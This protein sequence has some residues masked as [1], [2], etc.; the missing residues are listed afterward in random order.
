MENEAVSL[1]FS[2]GQRRLGFSNR[3]KT[4]ICSP[5]A[6]HFLNP[7]KG[8][9]KLF[10]RRAACQKCF[11]GDCCG[12]SNLQGEGSMPF[13]LRL[14]FYWLAVSLSLSAAVSARAQSSS[15]ALSTAQSSNESA[16]R[17]LT[18]EYFVFYA[19]K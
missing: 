12:R 5:V 4:E 18:Q 14:S 17:A 13:T 3:Q 1:A 11:V 7:D 16:V 6:S 9:P 15:S 2:T 8:L 10:C 19:A